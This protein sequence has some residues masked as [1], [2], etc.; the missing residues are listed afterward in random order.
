MATYQSI[1]IKNNV[2][3]CAENQ[4]VNLK[5][6]YFI[7]KHLQ[8][9]YVGSNLYQQ[10]K[11]LQCRK[12]LCPFLTR[13]D[14]CINT[15]YKSLLHGR[16]WCC[17]PKPSLKIRTASAIFWD[18]LC[19]FRNYGQKNNFFR[20]KTFLFFRIE[21][22]NFQHLCEIEFREISQNFNSFRQ[23]LF[24]FFLSVVWLSWNFVMLHEILF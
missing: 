1:F 8:R 16:Y 10:K 17:S 6:W 13:H 19:M 18:Y 2:N 23:L 11:K 12:K 5:I 3:V 14:F 4:S 21:S 22:W 24:S 9:N 20:N 7:K 15:C